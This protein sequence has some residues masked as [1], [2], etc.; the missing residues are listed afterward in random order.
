MINDKKLTEEDI[1]YSN[2]SGKKSFQWEMWTYCKNKC[3]FCYLGK[4]N[5]NTLE[6]R[7]LKSIEDFNSA[8]QKLDYNI[9]NNISIIGGEL[10]QGEAHSKKVEENLLESFK[11][12]GHLYLDKKIGSSWITTTFTKKE[13]FVIYDLLDY[14]NDNKMFIPKKKY[15]ASGLWLCTSWDTKGRFHTPEYKEN[16]EYHMLNIKNKY[17]WIKFNTTIIL[18]GPFL[19]DYIDNKWSFKEFQSKFSTTLFFKQ[20]GLGSQFA[21]QMPIIGW[22]R[23]PETYKDAIMRAKKIAND[24]YKWDFFPTRELFIEFLKKVYL[25]D[26]NI[27]DKLFNINYRADEVFRNNNNVDYN[28]ISHRSKTS[29]YEDE[30]IHAYEINTCGHNTTYLCYSDSNECCLCDKKRIGEMF[31]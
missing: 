29:S 16:W 2:N 26:R 18:T 4:E 30:E 28:H 22:D 3:V 23:R 20:S 7:Q 17:P 10:F 11:Q 8:L 12:L 24:Y 27:Y 5:I 9:Y 6:E 31:I 19:K 13:Q 14:Y 21:P 25:E 1:L 15:G